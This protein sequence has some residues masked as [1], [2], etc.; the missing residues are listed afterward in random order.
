MNWAKFAKKLILADGNIDAGEAAMIKAAILED[1]KVD[2]EEVEFLVDL[3]RSA[4]NVHADF[5]AFVFTVLKKVVLA[6]GKITDTEAKW[7]RGIIF[8]DGTISA[9]EKKFVHDLKAEAHASGPEFQ[10]LCKDVLG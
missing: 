9:A 6:D 7:L 3:K 4:K 2:K 10:K 8:A 5:D 1:H